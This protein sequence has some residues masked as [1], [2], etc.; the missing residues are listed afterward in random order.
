MIS[1]ISVT[2]DFYLDNLKNELGQI[3]DLMN[4]LLSVSMIERR[5]DDPYSSNDWTTPTYF[6]GTPSDDE[7]LIMH[8]LKKKNAAW[9]ESF[10]ALNS[11]A[12]DSLINKIR[13]IKRFIINWIEKSSGDWSVP[14]NIDLAKQLFRE[15]LNTM[16]GFLD[17]YQSGQKS[18][19]IIVPDTG[20]IIRHPD[21]A[22]YIRLI[23]K[24]HFTFILLPT[25]LS[26]LDNLK[27]NASNQ[28]LA[29][30]TGSSLVKLKSLR[31]LGDILEGV[32]VNSTISVK[33]IATEPDFKKT[34]SWL[35]PSNNDDRII[36]G[37]LEI[38]WANPT[39][40]VI[41]VS[42]DINLQNKA[43]LALLPYLDIY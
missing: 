16:S 31:D 2:M 25:V 28:D 20:S 8:Q 10:E 26:E 5:V 35:D 1:E 21:P 32:K 34:L 42:S 6:W 27:L 43:S 23:N 4:S 29:E 15:R 3:N 12:P 33:M 17:F 14:R 38:Q 22:H 39:D 11:N 19:P 18:F 41:L 24:E 9:F 7:I 36:A 40:K 30:R 37:L 13:E